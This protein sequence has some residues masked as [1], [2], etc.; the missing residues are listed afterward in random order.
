MIKVTEEWLAAWEKVKLLLKPYGDIAG[1]FTRPEIAG[2]QM[3]TI[4]LGSINFPTG[5]FL[6]RD[7]LV[8]LPDRDEPAYLR[9]VPVGE[10]SLTVAV[11]KIAEDHYRYAAARVLFSDRPVVSYEEALRGEE[12]FNDVTP[13][14]TFYGFCVDAGLAAI[15]DVKTRDL[16]CDFCDQW[17]AK[18][19][20]KNI[21]NDYFAALFSDSYNSN[22][23]YQR[24]AGDWINWTIPDTGL[25][26]AMFASGW[27]DGTYP[28]YFGLDDNGEVCQLIVELISLEY[29][30]DH[31]DD[32]ESKA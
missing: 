15:A 6:V 4:Q 2:Y 21:Y 8:Y 7:P 27:G 24:S 18:N 5:E 23:K 20:G 14:E 28:V 11:A 16:Y 12:E 30:A 3:D 9:K 1:Y 17:D 29:M 13:G 22:P 19:P 26:L 10:Y 31:A 25:S 32:N